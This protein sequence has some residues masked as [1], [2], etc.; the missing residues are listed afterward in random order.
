MGASPSHP[1]LLDWLAVEFVDK[2]WSVKTMLKMLVLSATYQQDSAVSADLEA[3]DPYNRLLARGP[4]FRLEA[5]MVRDVALASSGKLTPQVGGPSV[6]PP[7]PPNIWDNPYDN[8]RWVE[9]TGEDR[10]RRS[11]YTFH[12]RT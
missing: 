11:L 7:Q 5:E 2:G 1:E 9:S 8:S 10:Y 12:R 6:F 4:R 3:R